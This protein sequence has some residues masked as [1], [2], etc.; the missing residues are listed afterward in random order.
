MKLLRKATLIGLWLLTIAGCS[1]LAVNQV[2]K[3]IEKSYME[4]YNLC[5]AF[6]RQWLLECN[7]AEYDR[8][9]GDWKLCD[10]DTIQGNLITPEKRFNYVDIEDHIAVVENEL[11]VLKQQQLARQ[12]NKNLIKSTSTNLVKP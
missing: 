6:F 12:T 11:R 2:H 3:L 4:G 10:V 9:T 1:F 7:Y 5:N 8:K